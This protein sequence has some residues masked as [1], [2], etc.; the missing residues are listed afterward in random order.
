MND[1]GFPFDSG[2][3]DGV[4][5]TGCASTPLPDALAPLFE[6]PELLELEEDA[7]EAAAA[8]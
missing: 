7:D 2:W 5:G 3:D 6:L 4:Y 8:A 1:N